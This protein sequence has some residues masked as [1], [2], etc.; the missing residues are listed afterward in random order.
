MP[1]PDLPVER[2]ADVST[3]HLSPEDRALLD[4]Y[5]ETEGADGLS[6]LVGP[7]GW[8]VYASSE[9][10]AAEHV[11]PGLAAI[12]AAARAQGCGYVLFDR[13]GLHLDGVQAYKT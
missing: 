1:T 8:L 6:C 2:L 4:L 11:S 9:L 7:Y 3:A 12:L 13:D 5:I 10:R